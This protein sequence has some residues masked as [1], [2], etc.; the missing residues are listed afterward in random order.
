MTVIGVFKI[1]WNFI[2]IGWNGL[3]FLLFY[4][5]DLVIAVPQII[6]AQLNAHKRLVTI[7][8][9]MAIYL[10]GVR[11]AFPGMK[12]TDACVWIFTSGQ[13]ETKAGGIL[14][15]SS[16]LPSLLFCFVASPL[17]AF[18]ARID[19]GLYNLYY[20]RL[21]SIRLSNRS[22]SSTFDLMRF[23]NYREREIFEM[24]EFKALYAPFI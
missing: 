23:G 9:F 8:I 21:K 7:G 17:A 24:E 12:Y 1:G 11:V 3:F 15:V 18:F 16:L 5:L 19:D 4:F 20:M 6:V 13:Y 10:I 2:K 14:F 22:I